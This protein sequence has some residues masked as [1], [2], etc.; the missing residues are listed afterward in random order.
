MSGSPV[1][2]SPGGSPKPKSETGSHDKFD[3][4]LEKRPVRI[5]CLHGYASN[6][7]VLKKQIAPIVERLPKSYE[8]NY[9]DGLIYQGITYIW[10]HFLFNGF[11]DVILGFGQGGALAASFLLHDRIDNPSVSQFKSA[12]FICPS[13]PFSKCLQVGYNAREMFGLESGILDLI[14]DRPV[15]IPEKLLPTEAQKACPEY[16]TVW[17]EETAV[18]KPDKDEIAW[19]ELSDEMPPCAAEGHERCINS[20]GKKGEA[21]G[22]EVSE[23]DRTFYQMFHCNADRGLKIQIPTA[24]IHGYEDPWR[25]HGNEML[26]LFNREVFHV[27]LH[28][29]GHEVFAEEA[30]EMVEDIK[31]AFKEAGIPVE[32]EEDES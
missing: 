12:I 21:G 22:A 20:R 23:Q 14:L 2:S 3:F 28:D 1:F 26:S 11:F 32:D 29:G 31:E 9:L 27:T 18:M 6:S 19:N 15:D 5:L 4:S 24:H 10:N 30:D 17:R 25:K 8:W 16:E 13:S 7:E